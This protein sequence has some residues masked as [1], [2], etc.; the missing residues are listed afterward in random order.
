MIT[1]LLG[2]VGACTRPSPAEYSPRYEGQPTEWDAAPARTVVAVDGGG[3]GPGGGTVGGVGG[4]SQQV[5]TKTGQTGCCYDD[6][7]GHPRGFPLC[8]WQRLGP[9]D[10]VVVTALLD[11]DSKPIAAPDGLRLSSISPAQFASFDSCA[12]DPVGF[13]LSGTGITQG[14]LTGDL[15]IY[16]IKADG[17]WQVQ[18]DGGS[19]GLIS[20]SDPS[21]TGTPPDVGYMLDAGTCAPF[22]D[23]ATAAIA[24]F[25][26]QIDFKVGDVVY[27]ASFRARPN[28]G[29][30]GYYAVMAK[31]Y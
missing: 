21:A 14:K 11:K 9:G 18:G 20:G 13:V 10:A 1:F 2:A 5:C 17:T 15:Y 19:F 6:Q 24:V 27:H 7:P 23:P 30:I 25:F 16:S 3:S 29:A 31:G 12:K 4:G 22:M 8:G 26:D 28:G